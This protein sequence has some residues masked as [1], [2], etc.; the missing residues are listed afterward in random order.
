VIFAFKI[1]DNSTCY[2]ETPVT[3]K[4]PDE[5]WDHCEG[6]E[7]LVHSPIDCDEETEKDGTLEG[8]SRKLH[9]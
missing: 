3:S 1:S 5:I 9:K 8:N 4:I 2:E 7:V 6:R